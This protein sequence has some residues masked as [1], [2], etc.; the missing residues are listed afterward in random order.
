MGV[1]LFPFYM[2]SVFV[3]QHCFELDKDQN[4]V[5]GFST[6]TT[7]MIKDCDE[8]WEPVTAACRPVG[9]YKIVDSLHDTLLG[10]FKIGDIVRC[11]L[12]DGEL[13]A[14]EKIII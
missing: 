3:L 4:W 11:E 2:N 6:V 9:T 10:E 14:V 7:I 1:F 12:I 5:R 13:Y 8:K